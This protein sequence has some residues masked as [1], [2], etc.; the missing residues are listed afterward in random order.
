MK[1]WLS[2]KLL[3]SMSARSFVG[4]GSRDLCQMVSRDRRELKHDPGTKMEWRRYHVLGRPATTDKCTR[5]HHVYWVITNNP[6][7]LEPPTPTFHSLGWLPCAKHNTTT[8]HRKTD[9]YEQC[10]IDL[11][12][13]CSILCVDPHAQHFLRD[14]AL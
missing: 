6:V 5:F 4:K 11:M 1:R 10:H 14:K 12:P 13:T 7:V 2:C 9:K 8:K 3:L